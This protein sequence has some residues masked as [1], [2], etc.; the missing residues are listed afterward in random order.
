VVGFGAMIGVGWLVVM[1]GWLQRGG[2]IGA[3]LG[4]FL[5]ASLLLPLGYVYSR[6]VIAIPD[7]ND[8]A[9]GAAV[10]LGL[11]SMK[12]LPMV[13]RHFSLWEWIA[14]TFVAGIGFRRKTEKPA[15]A[16]F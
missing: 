2:P 1:D 13:P 9:A 7:A 16:G 4:F 8:T 14:L 3:M 5:G 6:L 15:G 10:S 12:A 11:I